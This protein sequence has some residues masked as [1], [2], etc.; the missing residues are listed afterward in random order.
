MLHV[1]IAENCAVMFLLDNMRAQFHFHTILSKFNHAHKATVMCVKWNHN[2]NWLATA[3]RDRSPHQDFPHQEEM[4]C[5]LSMTLHGCVHLC[6]R[7]V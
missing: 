3:T 5:G 4:S 7:G 2:G 6:D 1:V